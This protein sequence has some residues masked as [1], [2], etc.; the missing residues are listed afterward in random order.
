[1][2]YRIWTLV[3]I[4]CVSFSCQKQT[5]NDNSSHEA[6]RIPA[7]DPGRA[8][9]VRV[10]QLGEVTNLTERLASGLYRGGL[11]LAIR[12]DVVSGYYE[13]A[14]GWNEQVDAPQFSCEYS[15]SGKYTGSDTIYLA[16]KGYIDGKGT[17][18]ILSRQ[19]IRLSLSL[20][21][22]ENEQP[23]AETLQI[24]SPYRLVAIE[25]ISAPKSYFYSQ[26]DETSRRKAYLVKGDK[27][28]VTDVEGSWYRVS[29]RGAKSTTEG[30]MPASVFGNEPAVNL[31]LGK[32]LSK[33][34]ER[35][36]LYYEFY[37]NNRYK[38]WALNAFEPQGM[39]GSFA[40]GDSGVI[41]LMPCGTNAGTMRFRDATAGAISL[42]IPGT[43][44]W[45]VFEKRSG[46]AALEEAG[47]SIE[48]RQI[49][50]TVNSRLITIP[51]RA[52][53]AEF[54]D[55]VCP[56]DVTPDV[57]EKGEGTFDILRVST[58]EKG[59]I[60][61]AVLDG[62][63]VTALVTESPIVK[64]QGIAAGATFGE[65]KKTIPAIT[66]RRSEIEGKVLGADAHC[67]YSFGYVSDALF[68]SKMN[69]I[70][71]TVK[72]RQIIL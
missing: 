35:Y 49:I 57:I 12:G 1:M 58:P 61:Y 63:S 9:E 4:L 62:N 67:S 28:E 24:E 14:S 23:S 44:T 15:F 48:N 65:L 5:T 59:R 38:T 45:T 60:F 17:L 68:D 11:K 39:T 30:W 47:F 13:D 40:A 21:P 34:G 71:D 53:K 33:A 22:C 55:A 43:E 31:I 25:S 32:W 20:N 8:E 10:D 70:P 7:E 37:P 19:Q 66:L 16:L 2:R 64:R 50:T 27:A 51:S 46:N 6:S 72:I 18:E 36:E 56:F 54:L 52:T 29:Y 26:P 41:S 3:T 42:M 69:S